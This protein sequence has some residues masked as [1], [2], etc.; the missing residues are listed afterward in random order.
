MGGLGGGGISQIAR[1]RK[2]ALNAGERSL[3]GFDGGFQLRR[4]ALRTRMLC[5]LGIGEPA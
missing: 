1:R 5:P 2:L 3:L 4:A